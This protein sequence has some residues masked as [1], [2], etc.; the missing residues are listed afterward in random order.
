MRVSERLH[1]K[2]FFDLVD[3]IFE[4]VDSHYECGIRE[5]LTRKALKLSYPKHEATK[6][7]KCSSKHV[8]WRSLPLEDA[9]ALQG[10]APG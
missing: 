1:K 8:R 4:N 7:R 6:G 3:S 10:Q 2:S 5:P 9:V